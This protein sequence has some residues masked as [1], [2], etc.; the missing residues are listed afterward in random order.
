ML[1]I[2]KN[3]NLKIHIDLPLN[4]Y[5]GSRFDWTGKI[6]QLRFQGIL[7]SSIERLDMSNKTHMGKGLY[8]EFGIDTAL[9]FEEA[10][11]GGWFHKIGIGLLKKKD[12]KYFFHENHEINPA[13]FKVKSIQNKLII[14]CISATVNGYAYVLQ[15]EIELLDSSFNIKYRLENTGIKTIVTDEYVHNFLAIG[16]DAIG[17]YYTL[18]FPFLLRPESFEET[19]NPEEKVNIGTSEVSFKTTPE[20]PFFFSNLAGSQQVQAIWK[21]VHHQQGIGMSET[22]NFQTDKVN[23]WGWKHVI[24]PELF[25][26]I[27]LKAGQSITWSRH[28]H[29]FKV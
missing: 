28:Y 3:K 10:E 27:E 17:Q 14:N 22:G 7:L 15:K 6:R 12:T 13:K 25:F 20:Q 23:L 11:I 4:H 26:K 2:L 1:H 21:L 16:Q 19:V 8:N 9:G 24:S 18:T 5:Q 29:I